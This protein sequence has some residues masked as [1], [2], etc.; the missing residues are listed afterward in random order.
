MN[1][2]DFLLSAHDYLVL[3]GY[4]KFEQYWFLKKEKLVYC[5]YVEGGPWDA[6]D[7]VVEVG[8]AIEK[9]VGSKP[10]LNKWYVRKRCRDS[11][12]NDRNI[13]LSALMGSMAFFSQIHSVSE[14]NA[15]LDNTPHE[16]LGGQ[17]V[18]T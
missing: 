2:H 5:V 6:E 13:P 10:P 4:R 12:K 8:I 15:Y 18:L 17:Y 1:K 3:L 9:D 7:Y 16:V 11:E 14:L